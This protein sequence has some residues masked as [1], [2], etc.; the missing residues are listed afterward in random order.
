MM[1]LDKEN[2][3]Q[4]NYSFCNNSSSNVILWCKNIIEIQ[5]TV[6]Q[7]IGTA[8]NKVKG[9][10]TIFVV[11]DEDNLLTENQLNGPNDSPKGEDTSQNTS[12]KVFFRRVDD[13]CVVP[14]TIIPIL[15]E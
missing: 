3:Q 4:N 2:F 12:F 9:C 1:F 11:V 14:N 8:T 6:E 15:V 13:S 7:D 5:E 10:Q